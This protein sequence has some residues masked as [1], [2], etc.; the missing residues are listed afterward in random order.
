MA[1]IWYE[2]AIIAAIF[3]GVLALTA[4]FGVS[5]FRVRVQKWI[6]GA[7]GNFMTNLAKQAAKEGGAEGVTPGV[8]TLPV[9]GKVDM[10]TIGQLAS[11]AKQ[12]GLFDMLKKGGRGGG[13][14]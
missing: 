7:I 3:A 4:T 13:G 10:Q 9:V 8:I 6:G 2:Y 5:F 1:L 12:F 14:W 11:L